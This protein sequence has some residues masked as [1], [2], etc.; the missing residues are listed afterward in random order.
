ML[1]ESSYWLNNAYSIVTIIVIIVVFDTVLF[2]FLFLLVLM[3]L[4]LLLKHV[5]STLKMMSR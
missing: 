4:L 3:L 1:T 2:L 5:V